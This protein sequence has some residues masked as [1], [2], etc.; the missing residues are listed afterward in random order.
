M[1]RISLFA[2]L[3]VLPLSSD[4]SAQPLNPKNVI[5]FVGDGMGLEHVKLARMYANGNTQPFNFETF[6]HFATMTH[7]NAANG[8]TDSAASGTALATGVKVN[9]GVVSKRI[10]G[11]GADLL[12]SLEIMKS[13]GKRTGLVTK[14][15]H[16]TDA[17]PAAFG[18]HV[19]DRSDR[20]GIFNDYMFGSR[21]NVL[22]GQTRSGVINETTAT[23][24]GYTI[25]RNATDLNNFNPA[26]TSRVL[27]HWTAANEPSLSL[28]TDKALGLLSL[29][30]D[31]FFLMVEDEDP[32]NGGHDN[33]PTP[34]KDGVL[35]LVSAVQVALDWAATR[36]D[37]LVIVAADHETGGLTVLQNNG[38]GVMP[39]VSWT[40]TGHT[41][42]P[43]GVWAMGPNSSLVSGQI[44]NTDIFTIVTAVPEPAALALIPMGS[45]LL[46][47]RRRAA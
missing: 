38:A 24:Q 11:D 6:P 17:T 42:T 32:D 35:S 18:A 1:Y 34:V 14:A 2:L 33:D 22:F 4:V 39:T 37:T 27:G 3:L 28:M 45:L 10:P 31:G 7:N 5:L 40:T 15:T 30:N 43:V 36:T 19:T 29:D 23:N 26:S 44:D 46:L 25:L 21:P 13:R 41:Q 8:T 9:N 12:T 16:I 20:T 47:R